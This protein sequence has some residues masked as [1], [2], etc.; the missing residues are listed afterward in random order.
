MQTYAH[1]VPRVRRE[2]AA[3]MDEIPSPDPVATRGDAA[4]PY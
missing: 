3:K 1:V 2:V 4:K